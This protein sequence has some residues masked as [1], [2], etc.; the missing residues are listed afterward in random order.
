MHNMNEKAALETLYNATRVATLTAQQHEYLAQ[1]AQFL[2]E[3][4]E[5]NK[6]QEEEK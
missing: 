1:C 3:K 5:L 6:T 4:L 2:A